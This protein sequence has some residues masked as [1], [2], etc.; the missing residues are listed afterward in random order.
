MT[1]H[2][3]LSSD[4]EH[5]EL[6]AGA[7]AALWTLPERHSDFVMTAEVG[8]K[9][10]EVDRLAHPDG[11]GWWLGG[12]TGGG[13]TLAYSSV[14]VEYVDPLG[15]ASGGSCK[16]K[17]AGGGI[18]LVTEGQKTP[19]PGAGPALGLA[20]SNGRMAYIRATTVA[21]SGAPAS[22]SNAA[23]QIVNVPSGNV[24]SQ[25]KPPGIPLAIGLGPHVLAVLSRDVHFLRLSWYVPAT[26][27]KLGGIGV[28]VQTA[29]TLAVNDQF[30][31]YRFGRTLRAVNE[32]TRHVHPLG[33]TAPAYV[34][35]S[36]DQGRLVWAEN[37]NGHGL[38][39]A[40]SLH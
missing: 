34:G 17:I 39:R 12:A 27:R 29:S 6:A 31:V 16:K 40:L 5:L 30:V 20:L 3:T 19:L 38:I 23:V 26:G 18:D 24:V 21:K 32:A 13:T 14:D 2:W 37:Q 8:G 11:T 22:S 9:E 10:V 28:P 33:K 25:A 15:C 7:A 36:L 35:L 1:S 4:A